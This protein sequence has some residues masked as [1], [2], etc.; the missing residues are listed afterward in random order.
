MFELPLAPWHIGY[1]RIQRKLA[2]EFGVTLVPKSFLADI[3]RTKGATVDLAHLS[4][5]GHKI[6]ADKV[7][8]LL[9][10]CFGIKQ[11]Q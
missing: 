1:G 7:W 11:G 10:K 3:F 5:E 8:F 6:M 2:A 4:P 9:G